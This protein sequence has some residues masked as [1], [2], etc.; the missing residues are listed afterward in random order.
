VHQAGEIDLIAGEHLDGSV[1][2]R[3]NEEA[4]RRCCF[5][6]LEQRQRVRSPESFKRR[7]HFTQLSKGGR[8]RVVAL[9]ASKVHPGGLERGL[10]LGLKGCDFAE[11]H[12][13]L[14][15]RMF[16]LIGSGSGTGITLTM[17]EFADIR[18][19]AKVMDA[20]T[21]E[22][23]GQAIAV[24]ATSADSPV[25]GVFEAVYNEIPI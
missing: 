8:G 12:G 10:E 16:N 6:R 24:A 20:F 3:A 18:A 19:Y 25:T 22:P 21:T 5:T 14:D 7:C 11:A 2:P 17:W 13:S 1:T 23:A 15:A 4:L 9:Y